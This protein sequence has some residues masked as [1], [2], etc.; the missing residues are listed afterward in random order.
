MKPPEAEL[1][2]RIR[3]AIDVLRIHM[4]APNTT[5]SDYA[6][7]QMALRYLAE[8]LVLLEQNETTG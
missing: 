2:D 3:D 8:Q 4:S 7:L 6:V 5:H 1:T